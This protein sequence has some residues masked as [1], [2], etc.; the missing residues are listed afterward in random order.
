MNNIKEQIS[1]KIKKELDH[2]LTIYEHEAFTIRGSAYSGVR[3]MKE[4]IAQITNKSYEA[5]GRYLDELF[6][7]NW[8]NERC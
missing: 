5:T 8:M 2:K 4:I 6:K 3:N 7:T 1:L